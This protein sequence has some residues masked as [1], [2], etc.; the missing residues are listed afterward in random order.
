MPDFPFDQPDKASENDLAE[1]YPER[2]SIECDGPE[3][4]T[5]LRYLKAEGR[6]V[7]AVHIK[8]CAKYRLEFY[9]PDKNNSEK[10]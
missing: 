2:G 7:Y 8:G 3:F 5:Q 6:Y 10:C 1:P 4:I 9:T